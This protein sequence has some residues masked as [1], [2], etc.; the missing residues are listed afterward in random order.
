MSKKERKEARKVSRRG[1]LKGGSAYI[2]GGA[3]SLGIGGLAL[4]GCG[5]DSSC[6][7][8]GKNGATTQ[9][10]ARV[11]TEYIGE[12]VCPDCDTRIPHPRG[13]PC[14]MISCPK[15]DAAMGRGAV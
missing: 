3:V 6:R 5:T 9:T 4:T 15:C 2:I 14:R 8:S 1:F 10:S 11:D 13:V 7:A 12:C